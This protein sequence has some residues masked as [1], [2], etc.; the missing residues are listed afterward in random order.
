MNGHHAPRFRFTPSLV[1]GAALLLPLVAAAAQEAR[2]PPRPRML[3]EQFRPLF[4]N[5]GAKSTTKIQIVSGPK[6]IKMNRGQTPG[7]E[8]TATSGPYRFKLSI[9]DQVKLNITNLVRRL[10]RLPAPYIR[11]YQVASDP[12][13]N[14]VAAYKNLD[15]A[16]AHGSKDYINIVPNADA[17]VVAHEMGHTLEQAATEKDPRTL[18]KWAEAV[19]ADKIS[20]SRYGDSVNHE[21]LAEFALVYAVCLDAGKETLEKL[22]KLSPRRTALWES[23]LYDR[24]PKAA[25][26]KTR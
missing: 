6:A 26:S 2:P 4:G 20:V 14:G 10:E 11:G 15:G 3:M 24:V 5:F 9:E 17:L 25:P 18:E 13:E 7:K 19:K 1:L 23:I 12:N 8:W 21:D 16:A 22:R